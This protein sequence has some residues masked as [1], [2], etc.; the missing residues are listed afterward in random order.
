M[1]FVRKNKN[2]SHKLSVYSSALSQLQIMILDP[3][4]NESNFLTNYF[5]YSLDSP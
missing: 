5:V 4:K 1:Y 2:E 3:E